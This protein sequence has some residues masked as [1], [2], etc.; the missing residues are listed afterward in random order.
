MRLEEGDGQQS[1]KEVSEGAALP[2]GHLSAATLQDGSRAECLVGSAPPSSVTQ[3]LWGELTFGQ[4][5]TC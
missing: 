2:G 5:R 4:L 1:S 3:L